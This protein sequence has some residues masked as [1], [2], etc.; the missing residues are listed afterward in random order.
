M[1]KGKNREPLYEDGWK[2]IRSIGVAESSLEGKVK[3]AAG[4]RHFVPACLQKQAAWSNEYLGQLF[5]QFPFASGP[6]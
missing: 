3:I 2:T 4:R 6:G 5:F 1:G